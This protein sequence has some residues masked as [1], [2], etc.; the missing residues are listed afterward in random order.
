MIVLNGSDGA[1]REAAH[2]MTREDRR[3]RVL[4]L[5]R[6]GLAA[7]LNTAL[8]AAR[9]DL[10]AR[11]DSDDLCYAERLHLQAAAMDA[12]PSLL[13]LGTA[14]ELMDDLDQPIA[15]VRPPAEPRELRWRLLLGN[16]L[17]H[18]SMM[19]RRGAV[20]RLGG[21]D[22]LCTRS[23]DYELW[24]RLSRV[25]QIGCL[26]QVL[27]RHRSRYPMDPGRSTPEQASIAAEV[28]LQAWRSLPE[29]STERLTPALA[30]A[31]AR[32]PSAGAGIQ[33]MLS[34]FPSRE[35]LLAWLWAQHITPPGNRRAIDAA[36]RSRLREVG[37]MIRAE[38][39]RAVH[40]WGAGDHTR[41]VIEHQ[42]ELALRVLGIVDDDPALAGHS[43][44]GHPVGTPEAL[45]A[46]DAAL[47]SSDWHE[48]AIWDASAPHRLR[49]V[50]I[51][52][53][54]GEN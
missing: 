8:E 3:V 51:F 22:T 31:I 48:D 52:R 15:T 16:T 19:L 46:G 11:M 40:L 24:L 32:E 33:E 45:Q 54:Y 28:M 14:W 37:A 53:L 41:W 27:Y 20:L 42:H 5:P 12:D 13:A 18:G 17:A 1:T 21:Y 47:I 7:A 25:G 35:A 38:G 29:R 9:H 26:P 44:Y 34:A 36:K 23:Q 43:R 2:A 49:G 6:P 10:V 4:E 39:V 30:G 50:R